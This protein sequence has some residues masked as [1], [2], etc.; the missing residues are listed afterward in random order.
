MY[1]HT[2]SSVDLL[3]GDIHS[4]L[5]DHQTEVYHNIHMI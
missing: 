5:Y 3:V 2:Y 4:F 1:M